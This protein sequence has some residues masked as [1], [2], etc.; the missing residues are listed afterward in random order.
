MLP[1]SRVWKEFEQGRGEASRMLLFLG[2]GRTWLPDSI[3]VPLVP[4]LVK[5]H[6]TMRRSQ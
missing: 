6:C 3:M 2:I 1:V 5:N 4:K